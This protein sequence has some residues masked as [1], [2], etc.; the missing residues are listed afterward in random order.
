MEQLSSILGNVFADIARAHADAV[1]RRW[2]RMT[3][4]ERREAMRREAELLKIIEETGP[5]K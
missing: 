3:V 2:E 1:A 5:C 4:E